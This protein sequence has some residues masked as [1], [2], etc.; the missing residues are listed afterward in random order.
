MKNDYTLL[1]FNN[2][3]L[4]AVQSPLVCLFDTECHSLIGK[5]IE[6]L[7]ISDTIERLSSIEVN[8]KVPFH[9][10][11][12]SN[13]AIF[14]ASVEKI[15]FPKTEV[16]V[17]YTKENLN[18]TNS[19]FNPMI[20]HTALEQLLT[21]EQE[22]IDNLIESMRTT[23]NMKEISKLKSLLRGM[24]RKIDDSIL[25]ILKSEPVE[26]YQYESFNFVLTVR[27]YLEQLEVNYP[28]KIWVNFQNF[29]SSYVLG[30]KERLISLLDEFFLPYMEKE[31]IRIIAGVTQNDG[32]IT[33]EFTALP[34]GQLTE[35]I[36]EE[37]TDFS[38]HEKFLLAKKAGCTVNVYQR[39]GTGSKMTVTYDAYN[40]YR[41]YE[42][43]PEES[44]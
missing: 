26:H 5:R 33:A 23:R 2:G 20:Q 9:I 19:E 43:D 31:S 30:N 1:I 32:T 13:K 16:L 3:C 35:E 22:E 28:N 42:P 38:Q 7:F 21:N 8:K 29:F 6:E 34:F 24:Y 39:K 25:T 15:R 17:I 36:S 4:T 12:K 18:I 41:L 10:C 11:A 44:V 14:P 27:A 37:L 40:S